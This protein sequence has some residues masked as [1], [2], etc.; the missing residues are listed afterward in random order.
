MPTRHTW[1]CEREG[2]IT[3]THVTVSGGGGGRAGKH[4][5]FRDKYMGALLVAKL[6]WLALGLEAPAARTLNELQHKRTFNIVAA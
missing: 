1:K 3:D 2:Y 6:S 4:A 5:L